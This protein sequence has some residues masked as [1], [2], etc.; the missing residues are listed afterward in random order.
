MDAV[1]PCENIVSLCVGWFNIQTLLGSV[2]K[3]KKIAI[4]S[5]L[6]RGF[7]LHELIFL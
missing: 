3:D 7:N 5:N 6:V 1:L 4:I 2:V